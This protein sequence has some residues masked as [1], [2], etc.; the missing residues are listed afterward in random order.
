MNTNQCWRFTD[1]PKDTI[2]DIAF[3][4]SQSCMCFSSWDNTL[5]LYQIENSNGTN[6][7]TPKYIRTI[8]NPKDQDAI[9]RCDFKNS[10]I[11]FGTAS[12]QIYYQKSLSDKATASGQHSGIISGL[13]WCPSINLLLTGSAHDNNL[14]FWDLKSPSDKPT[15]TIDLKA[16]CVSLAVGGSTAYVATTDKIY[17]IDLSQ[18]PKQLQEIPT[19]LKCPI[20]CIT[21]TNDGKGYVAGGAYGI[22]EANLNGTGGNL[23]PCHR[24][25]NNGSIDVYQ[26]NC[27]AIVQFG[28]KKVIISGGGDGNC[29]Y[30]NGDTLT[31][32]S[33]RKISNKGYPITSICSGP[34]QKFYVTATGYDWSKGAEVYNNGAQLVEMIIHNLSAKELG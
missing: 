29:E 26:S 27:V 12:G 15:Q 30:F 19:K 32:T 6:C 5:S 7:P 8:K 25:E 16:K 20:T 33:K 24:E 23:I 4:P 17:K 34:N 9:L 11:V 31:Q 21:C 18:S 22:I 14:H 1:A 28:N 3:D 2:S 10:E 13:K